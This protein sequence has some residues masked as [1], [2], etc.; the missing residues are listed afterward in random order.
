MIDTGYVWIATTCL[1]TLL[2]SKSH[3]SPNVGRSLQGV[4]TLRPHTPLSENKKYLFSRWSKLSNG[5]IGLNPYGLYAY[6]TVWIIA[7][8]VKAFFEKGRTISFSNDSNL[9]K[10]VGGALNL[11]A[12]TVFDGI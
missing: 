3:L 10:A 6:D 11:A 1:S 2:D 9:H 7:N 5:T 4:L 12:M 8:A